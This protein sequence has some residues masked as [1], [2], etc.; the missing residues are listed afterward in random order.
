MLYILLSHWSYLFLS[1]RKNCENFEPLLKLWQHNISL[2]ICGWSLPFHFKSFS[3]PIDCTRKYCI[4]INSSISGSAY[5]I[6]PNSRGMMLCYPRPLPIRFFVVTYLCTFPSSPMSQGEK[7]TD[8]IL[9]ARP[10]VMLVPWRALNRRHLVTAQCARG[11]ERKI[12][13][14]AE[15][16]LWEIL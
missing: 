1:Q 14:L 15:E 10:C 9:K 7:N 13:W 16:E 12:R 11:E 8:L 6:P 4:S 5:I 2:N 3:P